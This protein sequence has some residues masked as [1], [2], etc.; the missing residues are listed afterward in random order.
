MGHLNI[1][2]Y[3]F[4]LQLLDILNDIYYDEGEDSEAQHSSQREA[5]NPTPSYDNCSTTIVV[6]P[7]LKKYESGT[8][9]VSQLLHIFQQRNYIF[10]GQ[11]NTKRTKE[12]EWSTVITILPVEIDGESVKEKFI[13]YHPLR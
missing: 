5:N 10:T 12:P 13:E 9:S 3:C 7:I 11:H 6:G 1:Q 4:S 8:E 2:F